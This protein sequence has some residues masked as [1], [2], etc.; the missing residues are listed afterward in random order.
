MIIHDRKI[1]KKSFLTE[2]RSQGSTKSNPAPPANRVDR[3]DLSSTPE[4]QRASQSRPSSRQTGW[5]TD[6]SDHTRDAALFPIDRALITQ[7]KVATNVSLRMEQFRRYGSFTMAYATLQSKMKYFDTSDGYIA[8]DTSMGITFVLGDPVAFAENHVALLRDFIQQHPRAC[9]CQISRPVA[10]ILAQLGFQVNEFGTD[11]ELDLP[12]YTFDGPSKSKLRQAGHKIDREGFTIAEL[13]AS[14]VDR[15]VIDELNSSWRATK[16]VKREARFLVRPFVFEDEPDVRK[17]YL[18]N[19]Q[20]RIVS[21]IYF[22]AIC[23]G[24]Q[25][26][27]YSPAV[28]RRSI[29]AP[30]GAE[31]AVTKFA[32]ERFRDEGKKTFKV[33]LMPFHQVEDSGF[34]ERWLLKKLF[35]GLYQHGDRWVY[36]FRGHADFKHRYRGELH[37]VYYASLRHWYGIDMI[38]LMRLCGIV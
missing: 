25:V 27:G 17:F 38:A 14:E 15:S 5:G 6:R 31:E 37:K 20:G 26:I 11:M 32:I 1:E 36:S 2:R 12:T 8:Y 16:T 18:I 4:R 24:G 9:F 21:F 3:S 19:P 29:A 28:K 10:E 13:S 7:G 23:E 33:G 30:T 34:R 35:Q 22:D